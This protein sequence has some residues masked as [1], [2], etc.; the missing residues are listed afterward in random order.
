[1]VFKDLFSSH[2]A[3]YAKYRPKYPAELFDILAA[4][5][6]SRDLAWDCGT[7]NGQA[8]VELAARFK[9]VIATDPSEKQIALA[10]K[11]PNI[12]YQV[13][14]AEKTAIATESVDLVTVAQALHWFK[15]TSFTKEVL[16]VAKPKARLAVWC[17]SLANVSGSVDAVTKELYEGILGTYWEPERKLVDAGYEGVILPITNES[18]PKLEMRVEMDLEAWLAYLRTWSALQKYQ[19]LN[20]RDPLELILKDFEKAW[21]DPLSVRPIVFPLFVRTGEIVS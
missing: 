14:P 8:A 10:P 11:N 13:A 6:L 16:R 3:N 20:S 21:G 5:C 17:Y 12:E 2:A 4:P 1:M 9:R 15:I 19:N 7:G 18:R